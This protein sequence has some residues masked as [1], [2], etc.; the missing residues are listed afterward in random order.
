MASVGERMISLRKQK[1]IS[2]QEL[3]DAIGVSQSS[4]N[5]YEHDEKC[6]DVRILTRCADFFNVS[7]DY[8]AGRTDITTNLSM[9][10]QLNEDKIFKMLLERR[11][12]KEFLSPDSEVYKE[13][14]EMMKD[15]F[16]DEFCNI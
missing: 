6:P 11:I 4:I 7:L 16:L 13:L 10:G 2:Q 15:V 14:K 9:R 1:G 8:L 5:R 3:G 12:I